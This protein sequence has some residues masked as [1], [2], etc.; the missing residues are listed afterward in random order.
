MS[1]VCQNSSVF[2]RQIRVLIFNNVQ[3]SLLTVWCHLNGIIFHV[4]S[5]FLTLWH[6]FVQ[7]AQCSCLKDHRKMADDCPTIDNLNTK[8]GNFICGVVEGNFESSM[9]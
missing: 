9:L 7:R 1:V 8:N 5:L 4:K 2:I 3:D 6:H